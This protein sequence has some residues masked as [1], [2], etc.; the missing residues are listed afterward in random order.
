MAAGLMSP[1]MISS[2]FLTIDRN[3]H[4][5]MSK[6]KNI[7]IFS[8]VLSQETTKLNGLFIILKRRSSLSGYCMHDKFQDSSVTRFPF[9]LFK[10][11]KEF[12]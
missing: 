1:E 6:M 3:I 9:K 11:K 8:N 2:L 4:Y 12:S 5:D 7:W 10:R